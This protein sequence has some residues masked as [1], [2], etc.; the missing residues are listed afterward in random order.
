[1]TGLRPKIG[2][3][4]RSS[5]EPTARQVLPGLL[6]CGLSRGV[7]EVK[8]FVR[9]KQAMVFTFLLPVMLLLLFGAIFS[10]NVASTDVSMKQVFTTGIIASGVMS[11]SFSSLAI[12][13]AIERDD[14]TLKRLAATPMPRG[15]YFVGKL[16]LVV[17]TG[18]AEVVV[19]LAIGT[20]F[21]GLKLPTSAGRW[22]TFSWVFALGI[23][24][25]ALMGIA[26]SRVAPNARSAA[27]V[28]QPPYLALQF[29]SGV[30]FVFSQLPKPLQSIAALFPLKWL[31]QGLRAV[32]LPDGYQRT[33]MAGSWELGRVAM[34]LGAWCVGAFIL[35]IATFRWLKPDER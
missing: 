20:G 35:S 13:I 34:V 8:S 14:G 5:A 7:V 24:A 11:V 15:A 33:E 12:S 2:L 16:I 26:Y 31:A 30:Y 1:M 23:V 29:I 10:G 27:A 22:I 3:P 21:Y 17:I 19:L 4:V 32:F 6:R 28:V 9:N 18:L 25:C